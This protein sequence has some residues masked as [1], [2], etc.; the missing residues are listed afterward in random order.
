VA[1]V[2]RT[3][4]ADAE[5]F[6]GRA[7]ADLCCAGLPMVHRDL[8]PSSV[9]GENVGWI[10]RFPMTGRSDSAAIMRD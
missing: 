7:A 3:V 4:T 2:P 6:L 10:G 8:P 1:K 5:D 9:Y